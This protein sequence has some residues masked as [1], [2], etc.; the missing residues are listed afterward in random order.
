LP[1]WHQLDGVFCKDG[2][3]SHSSGHGGACSCRQPKAD[4]RECSPVL[5]LQLVRAKYAVT[6]S[7]LRARKNRAF[8]ALFLWMTRLM[9]VRLML[10]FRAHADMPP[11]SLTACRNNER[12]LLPSGPPQT[13]ISFSFNALRIWELAGLD[14][15]RTL[16][17]VV[18]SIPVRRAH[19]DWPPARSTSRRNRRT[20]SFPLRSPSFIT[21]RHQGSDLIF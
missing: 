13:S 15:C 12:R 3:L 9:V 16:F 8:G 5:R 2:W 1:F 10:V 19:S 17:R 14:P 18:R 11:A 4:R 7:K 21:S 6:F 20:T